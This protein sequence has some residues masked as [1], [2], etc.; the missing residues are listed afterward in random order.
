[1][2]DLCVLIFML[3]C[4][5]SVSYYLLLLL[6]NCFLWYSACHWWNFSLFGAYLTLGI[7]IF[8]LIS[9]FWFF[10]FTSLLMLECCEFRLHRIFVVKTGILG[11]QQLMPLVLLQRMLSI[12]LWLNYAV[13]LR[14]K[15]LRLGFPVLPLMWWHALDV[16]LNFWQ[17]FR[18]EGYLW[19]LHILC[20]HLWWIVSLFFPCAL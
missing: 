16:N 14:W 17:A 3:H 9:F 18:F 5:F 7:N 8:S 1:M 12:H 10:F 19:L 2:L 4:C 15:C 20:A 11:L 13:V 6:A